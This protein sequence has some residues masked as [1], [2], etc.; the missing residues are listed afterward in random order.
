MS[1][2]ANSIAADTATKL[3][4]ATGCHTILRDGIC[5]KENYYCPACQLKRDAAGEL[6][7]GEDW[8]RHFGN[9]WDA[10]ML[11]L[12]EEMK[13]RTR[14]ETAE[15]LHGEVLGHFQDARARIAALESEREHEHSQ[16][17]YALSEWAAEHWD[18]DV[19]LRPEANKY[20]AG[21]D[22]VWKYIERH[23]LA[24]SEDVVFHPAHP[25]PS[26]PATDTGGGCEECGLLLTRAECPN[27]LHVDAATDSTGGEIEHNRIWADG[28]KCGYAD[29]EVACDGGTVTCEGNPYPYGVE[30]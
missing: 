7:A 12:D 3:E 10:L 22:K 21:M 27:E 6:R 25:T 28:H 14:A 24:Q 23:A 9:T 4:K 8:K 1:D 26:E 15:A 2:T 29:A 18:T 13:Q 19:R 16:W 17:W 30:P 20:R 11:S 5:G